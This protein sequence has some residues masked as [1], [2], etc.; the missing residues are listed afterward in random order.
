LKDFWQNPDILFLHVFVFY[1]NLMV[2]ITEKLVYKSLMK[3]ICPPSFRRPRLTPARYFAR[4][5]FSLVELLAVMGVL[6]LL[7]GLT[8][9]AFVST[10]KSRELGLAATRV[11]HLMA[12]ARTENWP[13]DADANFRKMSVWRNDTTTG[14]GW[15]Q[16]SQWE[17]LPSAVAFEPVAPAYPANTTHSNYIMEGTQNSFTATVAGQPVALRF[18]EFLPTGAAKSPNGINTGPETCVM[19]AP[20]QLSGTTI[21]YQGAENGVPRNWAKVSANTLT[22]RVKISQP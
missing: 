12:A 3:W 10:S 6:A 19:L 2:A 7:A 8:L 18:L 17:E 16:V 21:T 11:S 9:P 15:K 20:G 14:T 5:G 13:G 4:Q 1:L 22:G